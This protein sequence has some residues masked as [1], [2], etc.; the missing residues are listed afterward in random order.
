MPEPP[1]PAPDAPPADLGELIARCRTLPLLRLVEALRADQARRWRSGQRL[2]AEAYL[3]AFP[4]LA[5]SAEDALVLIWG[6]VLLRQERG[7]LPQPAEYRERFPR[8]ADAL[9]AQFELEAH[10]RQLPATTL[11]PPGPPPAAPPAE[12]HLP[13][14][15]GRYRILGRLGQGGMGTVYLAH[16]TQLGRSVAL[17]VPHFGAG[18]S[19]DR[20]E[21]FYREARVAATLT[22]PHLCPVYDVGEIDGVHFLTMPYLPG[23]T[24]AAWL[25][26]HGPLAPAEA[27]RLAGFL[28]RAL[29]VA[30]RAGVVH[31]DLKPANI[32][33]NENREPVV[34]DFGLAR[35]STAGD[36]RLT[37][38]GIL[39]GTPAYLAPE[40]VG[41]ES[42]APS[43]AADIYSLGVILYEMLTGRLPY[44]GP[45]ADLLRQALT[46]E[47]Q[48]P[49]DHRPG[50]DPRLE[51]VCLRALAKDPKDRFPDMAAFA[52][53]L[54]ACRPDEGVSPTLQ[55]EAPV[56]GRT[57]ARR[58]LLA[59][60]AAVL[61]ALLAGLAWAF[62]DGRPGAD[63]VQPGSRWVGTFSFRPQGVPHG[64]V[65][66]AISE[67]TADQFRGSYT[68]EQGRYEWLIA[69]TVQGG[70]VRWEFRR[71]VRGTRE[72]RSLVGKGWVEGRLDGETMAVVFHDANDGSVADMS[73]RL[74][75]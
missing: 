12:G 19:P 66:V 14:K 48:S 62:W 17:K 75:K 59:S 46:R 56:P 22:H 7:E 53:A 45:V 37:A 43:P 11:I 70:N 2:R 34:M 44:G 41:G 30:H 60:G 54:E 6:E 20:V 25:K 24:L 15:F 36:P 57:R 69:G 71:S 32:M 40:R 10:L 35:R 27:V 72:S 49:S 55:A 26:R 67:R 29:D 4:A 23:E 58:M 3:E 28:A 21:R 61:A 42:E 39:V 52:A 74:R 33:L 31:R 51:A 5:A 1:G 9:A 16:D 18:E 65:Q 13:E 8:H 63:A 47:P 64:D 68:T 38:S 73:L 50:L